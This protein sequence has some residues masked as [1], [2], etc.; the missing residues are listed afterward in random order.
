MI[1][2]RERSRRRRS[3]HVHSAVPG[4]REAS[5]RDRREHLRT[6]PTGRSQAAE[7]QLCREGPRRASAE[8]EACTKAERSERLKSMA[9]RR[10]L[11]R[12]QGKLN[13]SEAEEKRGP[14]PPPLM[15]FTPFPADSELQRGIGLIS[16]AASGER[17]G[18]SPALA[19]CLVP[20]SAGDQRRDHPV[21]LESR[22]MPVRV[23]SAPT[24]PCLQASSGAR[25]RG[26]PLCGTLL[27]DAPTRPRGRGCFGLAA[28]RSTH[29]GDLRCS[30]ALGPPPMVPG[31][32]GLGTMGSFENKGIVSPRKH[33]YS[34]GPSFSSS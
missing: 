9:Q 19:S 20:A 24:A 29:R 6:P 30:R 23:K 14:V 11:R 10:R 31:T 4:S 5:A 13:R 22:G 26:L 33:A 16:G 15:L 3:V 27:P 12:P 7:R 28:P 21:L 32:D 1:R 2:D 25:Q 8:G 34:P 17:D 18:S